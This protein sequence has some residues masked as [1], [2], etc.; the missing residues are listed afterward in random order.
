MSEYVRLSVS[1]SVKLLVKKGRKNIHRVNS[2]FQED[3]QLA[4]SALLSV[5]SVV[6][7]LSRRQNISSLLPPPPPFPPLPPPPP[8]SPPPLSLTVLPPLS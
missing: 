6:T 3:A 4:Y 5:P 7:K 1:T 2:F 8:P